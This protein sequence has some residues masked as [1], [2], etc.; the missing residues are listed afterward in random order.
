[1]IGGSFLKRAIELQDDFQIGFDGLPIQGGGLVSPLLDGSDGG[2]V[3][4]IV[5][6]NPADVAYSSGACDSRFHHDFA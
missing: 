6:A 4:K 3:E 5:A 1:M 2:V